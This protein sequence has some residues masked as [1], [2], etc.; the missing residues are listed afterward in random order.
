[1]GFR[2]S[3]F[4]FLNFSVFNWDGDNNGVY[5]MGFLGEGISFTVI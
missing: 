3:Y 2:I 4:S 1:M 5:F